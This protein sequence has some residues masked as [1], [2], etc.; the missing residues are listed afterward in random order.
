MDLRGIW[1]TES[2]HELKR[3]SGLDKARGSDWS[4]DGKLVAV[5][6]DDAIIHVWDTEK[7][8]EIQRLQ[9]T[10]MYMVLLS[11]SPDDRSLF[12]IAL[13]NTHLQVYDLHTARLYKSLPN[14]GDISYVSW[15]PSGEQFASYSYKNELPNIWNARSGDNEMVLEGHEGLTETITWSPNGDRILTTCYDFKVR[16]WNSQTGEK[17]F[18][19]IGHETKIE[20]GSWSH[21]GNFVVTVDK[22]G[23]IIVWNSTSGEE[24]LRFKGHDRLTFQALWS[25]TDM[26]I[27]SCDC[28]CNAYIWDGLTGN[29]IFDL[30]PKEFTVCLF[31][32]CWTGDSK[33]VI[34]QS[35]DRIMYTFD[36]ET[37]KKIREITL[38]SWSYNL[39]L[40]PDETRF[41]IGGVDGKAR[42]YQADT[43]NELLVYDVGGGLVMAEY[44]P[45]GKQILIGTYSGDLMIFPTWHSTQELI[46]YAKAHKV[47]RQLTPEERQRFG[48]PTL[49]EK[50]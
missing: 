1:D 36:A 28:D 48:L 13:S 33:Q 11:F 15:S 10:P 39:S 45:D 25:P 30:F 22:D 41:L 3:I 49:G 43:G 32:A 35:N 17:I 24:H 31:A 5:G 6:G 16:I 47:F 9:G 29:V 20:N 23:M 26:R 44:S 21:D 2:G 14:L 8:R 37:G 46:D 38:D 40:S 19:L 4:N 12:A 7:D 50:I 42:V 27:L 18:T 34:L